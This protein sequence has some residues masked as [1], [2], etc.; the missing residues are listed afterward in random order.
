MM[1]FPSPEF[2]E[3]VAAACQGTISDE[4]AKALNEL[5]RANR[6]ALDEYVLRV[7]LHS[8]LASDPDLFSTIAPEASATGLAAGVPQVPATVLS[9]PRAHAGR[10]QLFV[11]TIALAACLAILASGWWLLRDSKSNERRGATSRAVAMLNLVVDAQWNPGQAAPQTG[12]PMDPGWLRLKSG[13]AQVVF[14]SGARVV[15]EG[16]AEFQIISPMEASLRAGRL[17]AEVPPQARGFQIATPQLSVTDLGTVFGLHIKESASELHVFK[18]EVEFGTLGSAARQILRV[19]SGALAETGRP[20]RL[21]P[22]KTAPFASLFELQDRS[23]A[24]ETSRYEKWR[25]ASRLLNQDPTLLVHFDFEHAAPSDWRLRNASQNAAV[26]DGTIVGCQ[27]VEGRWLAKAALEFRSVSDRVRLSVP[28]EYQSLT[29]ATWVR[30]HGLDRQFNSL[31][32]CDG[33]DAGTLHWL[34]REDGVLGLT[35]IGPTPGNYQIVTSRPALGLDQF[36][37]WLH[38]GVVVDGSAK[39]V[40]HY[41]NGKRA[42]EKALKIQPPFRVGTAELGNWNGRGFPENDPFMIRNFSGAMD[43]FCLFSR[44]LS[45]G[46][47]QALYL[48]DPPPH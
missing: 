28:G 13:L 24:A 25:T 46:E 48:S 20:P 41:V 31:F 9:L 2:D 16:P 44:A 19:G 29:I 34:I 39:K 14:Y 6:G 33:F 47:I 45:H 21:V 7:E 35:A 32:M 11:W 8:R 15:I 3:A 18:G 42:G 22:A 38:V 40:T 30:I 12:A 5:L 23:A 43:E 1:T 36:G 10:K 26:S 27:W 17:I 37:M 4:Q